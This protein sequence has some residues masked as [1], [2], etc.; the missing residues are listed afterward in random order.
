MSDILNNAIDRI[1]ALMAERDALKA[2]VEAKA[3][4]KQQYD[5]AATDD[6]IAD[7]VERLR[8]F[9]SLG[10]HPQAWL[11]VEPFFDDVIAEVEA[12]D[13]DIVLADCRT[14]IE[15]LTAERDDEAVGRHQ[16]DAEYDKVVA[17]MMLLRRRV[18][19]L[20]AAVAK[21]ETNSN[22]PVRSILRAALTPLPADEW[23]EFDGPVLWWC[24]TGDTWPPVVGTRAQSDPAHHTHW[25]P[26]IVPMEPPAEMH[27]ED[28]DHGPDDAG[29][30]G[31]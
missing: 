15:R 27:I 23:Q 6:P 5:E 29:E 17:E 22:D 12:T 7:P 26:L 3:N 1:I 9:C 21:F 13:P 11:D 30:I 10:L 28:P 25:T 24:F 14:L 19:F 2:E 31:R 16:S 4:A 20:D 18:A 8:F